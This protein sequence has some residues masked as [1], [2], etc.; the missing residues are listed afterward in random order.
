MAR[1]V[2]E[3][4]P[5]TAARYR[6]TPVD[7]GQAR[8][9]LSER[10]LHC[11]VRTT[12]LISSIRECFGVAL[13]QADQAMALRPGDHALLVSLSFSVLLAWA[14]GGI[15]PLDEDWRCFLLEV[16]G[17]AVDA[18]PAGATAVEDFPSGSNTLT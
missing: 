15:A 3:H 7:A 17:A 14:E 16:E 13:T 5:R 12:E 6:A 8:I 10:E 18:T 2:I 4:L 11:L 1:F 9:W